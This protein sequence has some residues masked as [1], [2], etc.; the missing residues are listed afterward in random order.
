MSLLNFEARNGLSGRDLG[1]IEVAAETNISLRYVQKLITKRG[2]AY[3]TQKFR[4]RVGSYSEPD[5]DLGTTIVR[6]GAGESALLARDAWSR[7]G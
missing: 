6:A 3:F 4:R 7:L 2:C 1:P 5:A